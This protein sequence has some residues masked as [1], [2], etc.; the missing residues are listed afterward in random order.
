MERKKKGKIPKKLSENRSRFR[1]KW[2]EHDQRHG[3][4]WMIAIIL[5]DGPATIFEIEKEFRTAIR[6]FGFFNDFILGKKKTKRNFQEELTECL[7]DMISHDQVI[8]SGERYE[9]TEEGVRRAR[10]ARS[11]MGHLITRINRLVEPESVSKVTLIVHLVLAAIKLPAGFLSGSV[12]LINDAMDT[13][14]DGISSLMVFFG[15]RFRKENVVNVLLILFMLFT[16]SFT[17]Y[18]AI[19]RFLIP[20]APKVD[21]FAF[22]AAIISGVVCLGLWLYQRYSGL[23]NMSMVLITQ[24]VD[25]RNH[26]IVAGS[27][28]AALIAAFLKF[29]LLDTLVGLVVSLLILKSVVELIIDVFR[30]HGREKVDLSRYRFGLYERFRRSQ[31]RNWMLYQVKQE[32]ELTYEMLVEKTENAIDLHQNKILKS[33]GMDQKLEL[34]NLIEDT[35]RELLDKGFIVKN[36]FLHITPKGRGHLRRVTRSIV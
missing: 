24:S 18:K 25:S 35:V 27:V 8:K 26:V 29:T 34:G 28:L 2:G 21:W 31:L 32:K 10:R 22:T 14:L 17:L 6:R 36:G 1:E 15:I 11:E 9:L 12:G 5:E 33:L 7:S 16:G 13:L 30:A 19:S 23:R 4:G 3:M 20:C